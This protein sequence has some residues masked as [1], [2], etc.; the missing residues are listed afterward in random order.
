[1]TQR[2]LE[3]ASGAII[4]LLAVGYAVFMWMRVDP[5]TDSGSYNL[6]AE[7][8]NVG[9]LQ[10]GADVMVNG[11]KVGKVASVELDEN[12][13]TAKVGVTLQ[14]RIK[15]PTDTIIAIVGDGLSGEKHIRLEVGTAKQT[16]EANGSFGKVADYE[17][18]ED[19]VSKIIFNTEQNLE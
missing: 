2:F 11:I 4:L 15:L 14:Q 16:L 18:I 17:S 3:I 8:F 19:K 5:P 9:G 1:M 12:S 6:N 13:F 10:K 7:F